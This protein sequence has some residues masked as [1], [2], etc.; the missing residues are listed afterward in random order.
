MGERPDWTGTLCQPLLRPTVAGHGLPADSRRGNTLLPHQYA[1]V[2][3]AR[4]RGLGSVEGLS[5]SRPLGTEA[6]GRGQEALDPTMATQ[7]WRTRYRAAFD[8]YAAEL[9]RQGWESTTGSFWGDCASDLFPK[10]WNENDFNA[11]LLR[12][13]CA[14]HNW[15]AH[16]YLS[17]L[18]GGR[19]ADARDKMRDERGHSGGSRTDTWARKV[20]HACSGMRVRRSCRV[21]PSPCT[22]ASAPSAACEGGDCP[23]H[24]GALGGSGRAAGAS[25]AVKVLNEYTCPI[26]AEIMA[27]PVSTLG[28]FTYE[29]AAITEWL[30]TNDTSP[31]TGAKLESQR[32]IP[33]TAVRCL[34]ERV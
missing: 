5:G 21:T 24:A 29:R 14:K 33:N 4:G 1:D 25:V 12:H 23:K 28:G 27:E 34:L 6:R 19:E 20:R 8:A 22:A 26:P 15:R 9:S 17:C 31:P 2:L 7:S 30:R 3:E 32:L 13:G 10:G 18:I 16:H 11:E